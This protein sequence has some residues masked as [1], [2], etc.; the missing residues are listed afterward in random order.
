MGRAPLV[1]QCLK[2]TAK[3]PDGRR[4]GFFSRERRFFSPRDVLVVAAV[5]PFAD[6]ARSPPHDERSPSTPT[7][8]HTRGLSF[9]SRSKQEELVEYDVEK[10]ASD[11]KTKAV[12]VTGP[13]GAL[14]RGAPRRSAHGGRGGRGGR[15]KK[16][17]EGGDAEGGDAE[18]DAKKMDAAPAAAPAAD[19]AAA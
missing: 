17:A 16:K 6:R 14:V 7:T 12:N 13:G 19:A 11:E 8:R 15:G 2:K 3:R 1:G 4:R 18:G 10:S 9:L 5:A